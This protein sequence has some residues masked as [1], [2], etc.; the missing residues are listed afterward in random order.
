MQGRDFGPL[1]RGESIP[2]RSEWFYEHTYNTKPPRRPIAK[3][4]GVR[5]QRWK[6]IRY[7]EP[8][9][10]YE[11]LFDLR[12]DPVEQQNLAALSEHAGVLADMRSRWKRLGKRAG[13]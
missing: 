4:V 5:T 11:Q 6:Y 10:P 3:S 12:N 1:L 2:W 7:T 8:D 9:P 13:R